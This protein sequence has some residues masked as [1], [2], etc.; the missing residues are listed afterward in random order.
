MGAALT[1]EVAVT[2]VTQKADREADPGKQV[3]PELHHFLQTLQQ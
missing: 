2:L 1:L 3:F